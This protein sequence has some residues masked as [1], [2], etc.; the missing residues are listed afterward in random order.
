VKKFKYFN[1]IRLY[2]NDFFEIIADGTQARSII[3]KA[4]ERMTFGLLDICANIAMV[5]F[6]YG[7]ID[8]ESNAIL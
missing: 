5:P 7:T 2:F 3:Y 8:L 1:K 6:K 4:L